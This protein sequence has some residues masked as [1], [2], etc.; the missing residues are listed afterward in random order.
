MSSLE[1]LGIAEDDEV[2]VN[3]SQAAKYLEQHHRK[4]DQTNLLDFYG[5]YKQATV[6]KCNT[7]KPGIFNLQGKAKWSAWN[8]LGTMDQKVAM[9]NYVEKLSAIVPDWDVAQDRPKSG[10]VSVSTHKVDDEIP[11]EEKTLIDFLKEGNLIKLKELLANVDLKSDN[12]NELD[13]EGLGLLHWAADRGNEEILEFIIN[14]PNINVNLQDSDGQTALHYASS[15]GNKNCLLVL[16]KSGADKTI[17]DHDGQTCSEIA[18]DE[19]I[20]DILK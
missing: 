18:F 16:L 5:L 8:S 11:D 10:W 19:A 2:E 14:L 9:Q 6:G 17:V 13:E 15:C 1:D 3:F 20:Q 7:P 12:W 4:I